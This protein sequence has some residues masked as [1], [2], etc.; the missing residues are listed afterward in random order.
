[1]ALHGHRMKN[2]DKPNVVMTNSVSNSKPQQCSPMSVLR[3]LTISLA[4]AVVLYTSGVFAQSEAN[5]AGDGSTGTA[6]TVT[7]STVQENGNAGRWFQIEMIVFAQPGSQQS[8]EQETW[9][10]N[11]SLAYPPNWKQ[12]EDPEQAEHSDLETLLATAD[13]YQLPLEQRLLNNNI[14]DLKRSSGHRVLFHEAWRQ[15]VWGIDEAP[16]LLI[17]GGQ[18]YG[19]HFELEGS[20][21]LSVARYLHLRTNL[22]FTEFN[23]NFGQEPSDYPPLPGIPTRDISDDIATESDHSVPT[24]DQLQLISNEYEKILEQPYITSRIIAM[25]QKR[26]M[27]SKEIH[28]IDHPAIGIL[29]YII[30]YELPET[31][32]PLEPEL[33]ADS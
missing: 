5:I 32:E 7:T 31:E 9:P 24:W 20:I 16:S 23:H 30:P 15:Q 19:E 27:R 18:Q 6:Q 25:Q 22:W 12:L 26:R 21:Q 33:T 10:T 28:Y 13:Y 14:R 11:I 1:M 2:Y 4:T 3:A 29:M 17:K 8:S